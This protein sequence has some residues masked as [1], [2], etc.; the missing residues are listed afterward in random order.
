M[1]QRERLA[2]M[3]HEAEIGCTYLCTP[4]R[5]RHLD[6]ADALIARGARLEDE[7]DAAAEKRFLRPINPDP[8]TA[9]ARTRRKR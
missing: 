2:A 6:A 1:S 3:L 8:V 5:Q 9:I 7:Q 4:E